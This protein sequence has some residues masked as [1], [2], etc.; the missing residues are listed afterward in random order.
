M[1]PVKREE[2]VRPST[3]SVRQ[4]VPEQLLQG[5]KGPFNLAM[6]RKAEVQHFLMETQ[7]IHLGFDG[8]RT[9]VET[10]VLNLRSVPAAVSGKNLDEYTC[11]EFGLRLNLGPAVTIPSLAGWTYTFNLY[12]SGPDEKG[13]VFGI[14]HDKFENL[15]DSSGNK[16]PVDICYAI[17]NNF[18]D[19]HSFNDI[20]ARPTMAGG[21]IQDLK[22]IGQRVIHAAAFVEAPVNLGA[23]TKAGSVF[24][25]GEVTLELKG[26]SIVD[27][28]ACALITYDSGESTL[29]MIMP[30]A[31]GREAVTEGGS[32]YKGDIYVD[33]ATAWVRRVTLDEF[34]I[35]ETTVPDE[36]ANII[37]Y[38]ARHILLRMVS[39]EEIGGK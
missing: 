34:V 36:P 28:A 39:P 2:A 35:T 19:F 16:L 23:G 31:P 14:P 5:L 27:S 33:L 22:T 38:V 7:F 30:V 29:K 3:S 24:R 8:R 18:I 32:E 26:I 11:P 9:G 4:V 1:K 37:G 10:Y 12:L 15:V 17:Y 20:F 13:P 21:G 25:N 6:E